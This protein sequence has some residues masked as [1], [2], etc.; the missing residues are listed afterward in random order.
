MN[1][2]T[3]NLTPRRDAAGVS[4]AQALVYE[5]RVRDAMTCRLRTASP[6]DSLRSIQ[7]L[8]KEHRI[9]G[10]PITR[11]SALLGLVSIEDIVHA[12]D[13]GHINDPA[14]ARMTRHPV[15]M[16][17]HYSLVRAVAEFDRFDFGRFPV[18]DVGDRLVGIITRG[19]ITGALMHHLE[20]R[21]E[22]AVR[23]EA[24]RTAAAVPDE[25]HRRFILNAEVRAGDFDS[26]GKLSQRLRQILRA[27]GVEPSIRRR[28]TIIAYEAETNM[29]IHSLGGRLT[30]TVG[31]DRVTI[32]AVDQ[33]PGIEDLDLAMR[34]GWSTAG[35]LARKLG[36]GAGMGLPN[37]RRSTDQL[38]IKS[39]LANGTRL[40]AEV[41]LQPARAP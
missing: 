38:D 33:G 24:E 32:E 6:R 28:A 35:P 7:L 37:I 29:I 39:D 1:P 12:L 9:S 22:E 25:P 30:A 18:L 8:M 19:D 23:K 2:R 16:R 13:Q 36:F 11:D 15:V 5:L 26:A 41:L 27:R 21:A 20:R 14:E 31:A 34:E 3:E 4:L 17:D 40:H 10:V